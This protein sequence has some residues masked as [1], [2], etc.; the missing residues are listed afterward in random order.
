METSA[1]ES[2]YIYCIIES[3]QG[4]SFGPLGIGGRGDEVYTISSGDIAAVVSD[5][6]MKKYPVSREN[7]LAHEK[8]IEKAM[9][10]HV[11]L[12]VRFSTITEDEEEIKGILEKEHDRFKDLL[13][14]IRGKKELGLKAMFKEDAIYRDILEKYEN[15]KILKEKV[16][17]LPPEKARYQYMEIGKM[18]ELALEK[19]KEEH[20][21]KILCE[22]EPL[23]DEVKI[24]FPYGE[25]MIIN[26]AF[27]V[28]KKKEKEFDQKVNGLDEKFGD[29]I[30]FKYLGTIPPF[31]FINLVIIAGD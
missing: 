17:A 23:A 4:R 6:P 14:E 26:A 12:P 2:K 20:K 31:N 10:E 19:E 28:D 15:I 27:L 8:A 21:E 18:V 9:E 7:T 22:L 30:K 5:S 29:K 16:K 13:N 1:G 11:V 3:G 25:R 24:N